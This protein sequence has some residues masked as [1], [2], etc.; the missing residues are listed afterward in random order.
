MNARDGRR[1]VPF[2]AAYGTFP[3]YVFVFV[4]VQV[5]VEIAPDWILAAEDEIPPARRVF[6]VEGRDLRF[7]RS[8]V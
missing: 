2:A 1:S 6:V 7:I 3:T 5:I 4:R 8:D